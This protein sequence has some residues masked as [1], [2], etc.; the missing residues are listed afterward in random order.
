MA[1]LSHICL[2]I[3]QVIHDRKIC[4]NRQMQKYTTYPTTYKP[5]YATN[6][7][8]HMDVSNEGTHAST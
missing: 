4:K 1:R 3:H 5:A 7:R 2:R 6:A 8:K